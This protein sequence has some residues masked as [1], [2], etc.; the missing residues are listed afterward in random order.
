MLAYP[1]ASRGVGGPALA[2]GFNQSF[3][4]F[5]ISR[6]PFPRQTVGNSFPAEFKIKKWWM[7]KEG[8]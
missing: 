8:T 4:P 6:I 2:G 1:A 3:N 5:G 7:E